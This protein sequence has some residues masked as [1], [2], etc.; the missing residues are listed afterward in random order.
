MTSTILLKHLTLSSLVTILF[1]ISAPAL[2]A[3]DTTDNWGEE[4]SDEWPDDTFVS[5]PALPISGYFES[6]ASYRTKHN[7]VIANEW[8]A[9][10]VRGRIQ[11]Y[12]S[13][14]DIVVSY[15]GEIY[16]DGITSQWHG[17]NREAYIGFTPASSIDIRAGRQV[18]TWG[19]GDLLFLNDFFPKNWVAL[20]SGYDQQ[21]LKAPS[22]AVKIS[23][24]SD[25]ANI[26]L[27]LSPQFDSDQFITGEKLSYYSPMK[28]SIVAAPPIL[29]AKKP[30]TSSEDS[31]VSLR[32]YKNIEGIEY[33]AYLYK[34]FF[35]TPEGYDIEMQ[36]PYFPELQSIGA[37]ARTSAF[38]GI[39]NIEYAYW[40]SPES[41]G[42]KNHYVPNDQSRFLLGYE[43]EIVRNIT[44]S[45][46]YY[47]EYTHD[48][49]VLTLSYP[50][51][52]DRPEQIRQVLTTRWTFSTQ[53]SNLIYS[54]FLFYSTSDED[55]YF[56]PN[57]MYRMNDSWQFNGGANL[58][59]G[60]KQSTLFGQM[61]LNSNIYLR[62]KFIF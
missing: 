56:I 19:T 3:E 54:A 16:F 55:Y 6:T 1:V 43:T 47:A 53:Q 38:N 10:D 21:Y 36:T 22:D 49:D 52:E 14:H 9:Q 24:Y 29:Q 39:A 45:F 12:Y 59:G 27:I 50:S 51:T 40:N 48:Y 30:G 34:G 32:I 42:G 13:Q 26:D 41:D 5:T 4:W 62:A 57:V 58:L 46:Q 18:L 60:R 11:T 8:V 35:K 61:E 17:L 20:F 44:A 37:S 28:Q 23:G 15:K 25:F 7:N 31:E 2:K 33:A